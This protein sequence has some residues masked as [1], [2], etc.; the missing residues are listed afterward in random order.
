[1]MMKGR[2]SHIEAVRRKNNKYVEEHDILAISF[3]FF[4][5]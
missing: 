3:L 4:V 1:M 5:D 2:L